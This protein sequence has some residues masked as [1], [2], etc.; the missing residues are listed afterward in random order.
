MVESSVKSISRP[1]IDRLPVNVNQIN[2]FACR[3]VDR[4]H[5]FPCLSCPSSSP[6]HR[7]SLKILPLLF[8]RL[9][10]PFPPFFSQSLLSCFSLFRDGS[11]TPL[12]TPAARQ[13]STSLLERAVPHPRWPSPHL[14][15]HPHRTVIRVD[16]N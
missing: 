5:S 16:Q 8:K 4:V 13:I 11:L 14:H 7:H 12:L 6:H 9:L 2:E 3:Q 10:C 1:I 15:P